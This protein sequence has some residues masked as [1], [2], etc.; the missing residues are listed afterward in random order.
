MYLNLSLCYQQGLDLQNQEFQLDGILDYL[1]HVWVVNKPDLCTILTSLSWL[2][3]GNCHSS[4]ISATRHPV[5]LQYQ[6]S[7]LISAVISGHSSRR[8][9]KHQ[10]PF[11]SNGHIQETWDQVDVA[12]CDKISHQ[13]SFYFVHIMSD[14]KLYL[15]ETKLQRSIHAIG[16]VGILC[17]AYLVVYTTCSAHAYTLS[18]QLILQALHS[19]CVTFN[20]LIC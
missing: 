10:S 19:S 18:M 12:L 17:S 13:P 6:L 5:S 1:D 2:V 14:Q 9:S 20:G 3:C 15:L 8:Q 11:Y 16:N 7:Q 4:W